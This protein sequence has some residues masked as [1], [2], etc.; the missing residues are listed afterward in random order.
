MEARMVECNCVVPENIHTPS[1]S[2]LLESH[3]GGVS[4]AKLEFPEAL[5]GGGVQTQKN[6]CWSIIW[7]SSGRTHFK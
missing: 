7:I 6:L 1:W 4:K 2:R 5:G 3:G